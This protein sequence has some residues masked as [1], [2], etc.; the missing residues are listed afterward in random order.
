MSSSGGPSERECTFSLD[1]SR[2]SHH[3]HPDSDLPD[4]DLTDAG[5]WK[6]PHPPL[7]G[8]DRC[9]AH[10]EPAERPDDTDETAWLRERLESAAG[11][12]AESRRRKQFV[13]GRFE[14][15]DLTG[16][17]GVETNDTYPLDFRYADVDHLACAATDATDRLEFGMATVDEL[18]LEGT[19][20][21]VRA[22]AA[23]LGDCDLEHAT[24]KLLDWRDASVDAL[25]LGSADV[26]TVDLRNATAGTIDCDGATID[27]GRFDFLR[28]DRVRGVHA[29][30]DV[31]DFDSATFDRIN[32]YYAD[33]GE[34]DFR[35]VRANDA[36]FKGAAFDGAYFNGAVFG[37]SN[38]IGADVAS[39]HFRDA[40]FDQV[41][42]FK[43]DIPSAGF[44]NAY[45][46]LA[47][48]QNVTFEKADF[49]N[50]TLEHAVFR[51]ATFRT[52]D[53]TGVDC[54]GALNLKETT[55]ADDVTIRPSPTA[56]PTETLV[57]LAGSEIATGTF[58]QSDRGWVFYDLADATVG[59]VTFE[60][61]DDG[62]DRDGELIRHVRFLRTRFEHFDFRDSDGIDLKRTNYDI[63]SMY[64]ADDGDDPER[65]AENRAGQLLQYGLH[66]ASR[67]VRSNGAP[68]GEASTG[69]RTSTGGASTDNRTSSSEDDG[70]TVPGAAFTL[71]AVPDPDTE[72]YAQDR[73]AAWNSLL[74]IDPETLPTPN[75]HD[76]PARDLEYTYLLAKNGA[77]VINDNESAS[78]FFVREM[79]QRRRQY[80]D[81]AREADSNRRRLGHLIDYVENWIIGTTS[82]Y[83][84]SPA[85]V[86]AT[87][88]V[89]IGVFS[90]LF[91][92]LEPGLYDDPLQFGVLSIGSF[93]S[94][95]IGGVT[96]VPDPLISLLSQVQAFIGAFFIALFVFTLTRSIHR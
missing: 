3:N 33:I 69:D 79:L 7:E 94:F 16:G 80:L 85:R 29:T 54:A 63:H 4:D 78:R 17:V 95:I 66:L 67:R 83:G 10:L 40:R 93:V 1:P 51:G 75:Y 60:H 50:A 9:L 52:A 88:A 87:S 62:D 48:F 53:F 92:A 73:V 38:W 37:V 32:V 23:A 39:G 71:E 27:R 65:D 19:F 12:G 86:I 89:T 56:P 61:A 91:Y 76:Q 57:D 30:F 5:V 42:F 64:R 72:S 31:V 41:S 6:C 14:G 49:E 36:V 90:V 20:D 15:L 25:A 35:G 84:E 11:G 68:T 45:L 47:N 55:F 22:H 26:D 28:A 96:D 74:E 21:A 70:V 8:R 46:G 13:G 2:A 24:I 77:N 43:A 58:G 18:R 82:G 34:G 44:E 81:L 59:H